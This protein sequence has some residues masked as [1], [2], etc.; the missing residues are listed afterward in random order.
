MGYDIRVAAFEGPLDLLLHLI[1]TRKLNIWDIPV[2]EITEQYLHHLRRMQ[3]LSLELASEFLV[4]AARLL[5]MKSRLLLPR[6]PRAEGEEDEEDEIDP[7]LALSRRLAAYRTIK[8]LAAVLGDLE[9][10]R[11]W[12][13]TRAPAVLSR[14]WPGPAGPRASAETLVDAWRRVLW[15]A[16]SESRAATVDR[17]ELR[18]GDWVQVLTHRLRRAGTLTFADLLGPY[19]DRGH[20]VVTLLALLELMKERRVRCVQEVVFGDIWIRWMGEGMDGGG[21]R[22]D[23]GD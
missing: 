8:H 1:E 17:D 2:A 16:F 13:W 15:R 4:M 7:R 21:T 12:V 10:K 18:V 22:H 19:R 5:E 6:P 3:E 9:Q 14:E 20:V 23:G 11:Q